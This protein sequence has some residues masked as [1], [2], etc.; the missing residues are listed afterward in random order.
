M[1]KK[2]INL[3]ISYFSI[4]LGLFALGL[5]WKQFEQSKQ[6]SNII[7]SSLLASTSIIWLLFILLYLIKIIARQESVK[8]E[9]SPLC[10][11]CT[12]NAIKKAAN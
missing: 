3:P 2:F 4:T 11:T 9:F 12:N 10:S 8:N 1:N 6:L 5:A 7:S